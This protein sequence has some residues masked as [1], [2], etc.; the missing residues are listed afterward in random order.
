MKSKLKSIVEIEQTTD[1]RKLREAVG[2]E[3]FATKGGSNPIFV[4]GFVENFSGDELKLTNA[5]SV[6]A[7]INTHES[8]KILDIFRN[9]KKDRE[10][11]SIKVNFSEDWLAYIIKP[12]SQ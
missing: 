2:Y 1:M 6:R 7:Y 5:L 8:G 9:Y 11:T 3:I 4:H 10:T 12:N